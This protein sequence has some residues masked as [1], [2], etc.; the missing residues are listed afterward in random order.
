MKKYAL[1]LS[2]T[3]FLFLVG[4]D[5]TDDER[6]VSDMYGTWTMVKMT[7]MGAT[8]EYSKNVFIYE[9]SEDHII[10]YDNKTSSYSKPDTITYTWNDDKMKT[11]EGLTIE[12][13]FSGDNLI[14]NSTVDFFGT[15]I[16]TTETYE[17]YDGELPPTDWQN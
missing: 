7:A 16:T 11:E 6:P 1:L 14:L 5:V 13:S 4:C 17:K 2:L 10:E 12:P 15:D 3:A 8:E 9:I